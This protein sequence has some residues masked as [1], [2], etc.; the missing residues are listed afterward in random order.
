MKLG[1]KKK[2]IPTSQLAAFFPPPGPQETIFYLR[3]AYGVPIRQCTVG[4]GYPFNGMP[5]VGRISHMQGYNH[6]GR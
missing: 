1:K 4:L 3:V 2:K 5:T 6:Q